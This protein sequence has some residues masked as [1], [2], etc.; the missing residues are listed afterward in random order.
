MGAPS[1][2]AREAE[3]A[4]REKRCALYSGPNREATVVYYSTRPALSTL[5]KVFWRRFRYA[6]SRHGGP[7]GDDLS[8]SR[9]IW[10]R[11]AKG[12]QHKIA[13][14]HGTL[15]GT[16]PR[17]HRRYLQLQFRCIFLTPHPSRDRSVASR[18]E[19]SAPPGNPG[20]ARA[21]DDHRCAVEGTTPLARAR[22]GKARRGK[23]KE[24]KEW[25]GT[26]REGGSW[27][28]EGRGSTVPEETTGDLRRNRRRTWRGQRASLRISHIAF[29]CSSLRT[30]ACSFA[31]ERHPR[32]SLSHTTMCARLLR[33]AR[34]RFPSSRTRAQHANWEGRSEVLRHT[35]E[36]RRTEVR[37][38][39]MALH[40]NDTFPLIDG[41]SLPGVHSHTW[42]PED[43]VYNLGRRRSF[44][45]CGSWQRRRRHR[46]RHR[47]LSPRCVSVAWGSRLPRTSRSSAA[48]CPA[49][50]TSVPT[51]NAVHRWRA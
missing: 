13:T 4:T 28:C 7:S 21:N 23:A 8:R 19:P 2:A 29:H 35:S 45:C 27:R 48:P 24:G 49:P 47:T 31:G 40:L 14:D 34:P 6:T 32:P 26:R 43:A 38:R 44:G 30:I 36:G 22:Q 12:C 11:D 1:G 51:R 15:Y 25:Q 46:R 20:G 42:R 10:R 18:P 37:R 39:N 41:L 17:M 33:R 9:D 16:F 50:P 3:H 5:A